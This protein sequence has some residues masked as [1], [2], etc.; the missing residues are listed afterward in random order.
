MQELDIKI[1]NMDS[2]INHTESLLKDLQKLQ[3]QIATKSGER[4]SK[5]EE[6]QKRY[7]ALTEEN[8]GLSNNSIIFFFFP[9]L[10]LLV[11]FWHFLASESQLVN[12]LHMFNLFSRH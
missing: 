8:E 1:Q 9:S 12:C 2:E 11:C 5:F 3:G 6:V 7:A 4:K 10:S